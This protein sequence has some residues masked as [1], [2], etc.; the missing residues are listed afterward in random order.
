M[1]DDPAAMLDRPNAVAPHHPALS[2]LIDLFGLLPGG[3]L[4]AWIDGAPL[5]GA[6]PALTLVDPATGE[7]AL[8]YAEAGVELAS[9]AA[10]GAADAQVAWMRLS[11]VER[12]RRMSGWA[13]I[14]RE[15]SADLAR[16]EAANTGRPVR[17]CRVQLSR[18]VETI[19]YYAG[20]CDKMDTRMV[21]V[22]GGQRAAVTPHPYGVVA[23][24]TPAEAPLLSA[25]WAAAP[26]IAAGNAVIL[27]P[28]DMTPLS[29]IVLGLLA[30]EG[31]LPRG[32]LQV[33]PGTGRVTG[34]ALLAQGT[35]RK[36]AFS[37]HPATGGQV[38]R[39]CAERGKPCLLEL[40]GREANI[41][42]ADADFDAVVQ[43]ACRAAFSGGRGVAGSW[44]LAEREIYERLVVHVADR[45][46]WLRVGLPLDEEA[47][48]G[49]VATR[50]QLV[51]TRELVAQAVA[52]GAW[53][54][55]RELPAE[56]PA[57]GH[58]MAPTVLAHL[59][60]RSSILHQ[61]V[62]AP[63]L[64]VMPFDDEAEAVHLANSG[65]GLAAAVWTADAARARRVAEALRMGTVWINGHGMTHASVPFGGIGASGHGRTSGREAL[66]EYTQTKSVWTGTETPSA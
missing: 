2:H 11:P 31:G 38:A 10:V 19:E 14:V 18:V 17:D 42:F 35:V 22:P 27:K 34:A 44:L 4:G 49:P 66:A 30:S 61:A 5:P 60:P 6:G 37:G 3:R 58:W 50:Q 45:A 25:A 8:R 20:W 13:A 51:R 24:I 33:L 9:A 53:T 43:A 15:S 21:T 46:D 52:D 64:A 36:V 59:H 41:A 16:L 29:S 55:P 57:G 47:E 48:I 40:A 65:H 39:L 1:P 28:N 62:A 23:A 12:G 54:V 56:L 7:E 26:A 63:V 32:L